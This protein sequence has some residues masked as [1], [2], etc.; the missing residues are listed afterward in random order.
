MLTGNNLDVGM[1]SVQRITELRSYRTSDDATPKFLDD[2]NLLRMVNIEPLK[3]PEMSFHS[4]AVEQAVQETSKTA[5]RAESGGYDAFKK[6]SPDK[7][8]LS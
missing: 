7:E 3:F 2:K 1:K 5:Y 6:L 8:G 4:Q